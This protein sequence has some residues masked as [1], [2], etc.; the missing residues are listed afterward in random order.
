MEVPIDDCPAGLAMDAAV[1]KAL[2]F[3]VKWDMGV[4]LYL[5]G[6][7][8]VEVEEW[9]DSEVWKPVPGYSTDIGVAWGLWRQLA[10][11]GVDYFEFG[12]AATGESE[13][14][15][16]AISEQAGYAEGKEWDEAA[17][18]CRALLKFKGIGFVEVPDA[19]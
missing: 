11:E 15:F 14:L 8:E 10:K 4:P 6:V 19:D 7:V 9:V 16:L 5:V 1:A 2:G 13:V 3:K 17:T 12:S 18:I